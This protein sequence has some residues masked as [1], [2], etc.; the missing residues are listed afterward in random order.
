MFSSVAE[1]NPWT[2]YVVESA[3]MTTRVLL[4]E[5]V[6]YREGL[7]NRYQTIEWMRM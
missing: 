6:E 3:M 4:H 2:G 7:K 5:N 1:L